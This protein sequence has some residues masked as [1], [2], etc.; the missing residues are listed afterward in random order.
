MNHTKKTA[1][2]LSGLCLL[3][4]MLHAQKG[5]FAT[6]E[7]LLAAT[8][9]IHS[10]TVRLDSIVTNLNNVIN[11]AGTK[12]QGIES[13]LDKTLGNTLDKTNGLVKDATTNIKDVGAS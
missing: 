9:Q 10:S 4:T 6:S 8:K 7:Q 3:A 1:L 11:N 13:Q 5:L 12:V 2:L